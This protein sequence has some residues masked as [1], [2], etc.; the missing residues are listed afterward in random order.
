MKDLNVRHETMKLPENT[1]DM[2]HDLGMSKTLKAQE[3][4][5]KIDK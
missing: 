5:A 1:R 2:I 4:N 3:K